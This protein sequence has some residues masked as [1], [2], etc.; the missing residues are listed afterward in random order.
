[1]NS[2]KIA[3]I[4]AV[5]AGVLLG[6]IG[7]RFLLVPMQAQ[8]TFGLGK[9]DAGAALHHVI[10]LRDLWLALLVLAF[11]WMG[12]WKALALWFAFGA[13]VCFSDA[14]IVAAGAGRWPYVAFHAGSGI[15]CAVLAS[16][17]VRAARGENTGS[18]TDGRS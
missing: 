5:L 3:L 15:F 2:R 8:Y 9:G 18:G 7:V 13:L 1:M 11:A 14:A 17:A 16:V 4:A 6:V 10:A 12:N